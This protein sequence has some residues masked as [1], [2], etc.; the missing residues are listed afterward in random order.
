LERTLWWSSVQLRS[1]EMVLVFDDEAREPSQEEIT[2]YAEFLGIDTEKEPYLLWIAKEGVAAPIPTP[3]K[4]CQEEGSNEVFYFNFES[5]E[6]VWDH[7]CDEKYRQMAEDERLKHDKKEDG[8]DVRSSPRRGPASGV[9]VDPGEPPDEEGGAD[10]SPA[11]TP[12]SV[13]S[14]AKD[15]TLKANGGTGSQAVG[16]KVGLGAPLDEDAS[17][18]SSVASL[19]SP[20]GA[21]YSSSKSVNKAL[22]SWGNDMSVSKSPKSASKSPKAARGDAGAGGSPAGVTASQ[23]AHMTTTQFRDIRA[24]ALAEEEEEDFDKASAEGSADLDASKGSASG[25]LGSSKGSNK[26]SAKSIGGSAGNNGMTLPCINASESESSGSADSSPRGM[27]GIIKSQEAAAASASGAL[28]NSVSPNEKNAGLAGKQRSIDPSNLLAALDT[29]YSEGESMSVAQSPPGDESGGLLIDKRTGETRQR[30]SFEPAGGTQ[31]TRIE[32]SDEESIASSLP[33]SPSKESAGGS[34]AS[35]PLNAKAGSSA[36][37]VPASPSNESACNSASSTPL[38]H[39]KGGPP[40]GDQPSTPSK[41]SASGSAA[42]TP[43]GANSS[44]DFRTQKKSNKN[45]SESESDENDDAWGTNGGRQAPGPATLSALGSLLQETGS[46]KAEISFASTKAGANKPKPISTVDEEDE[47][48]VRDA[49]SAKRSPLKESAS[50]SL[51]ASQ[52]EE[53]PAVPAVAC[54]SSAPSACYSSAPSMPEE[55]VAL[56]SEVVVKKSSPPQSSLES[57]LRNLSD[58]LDNLREIRKQQQECLTCFLGTEAAE[59]SRFSPPAR[60]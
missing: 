60:R 16:M 11:S 37:E 33:G 17:V 13:T 42:S 44:S 43:A 25:G 55:C 7:P 41:L 26:G 58:L 50:A 36:R 30:N 12:A 35:T 27:A 15:K 8:S 40:P 39:A 3:W 19:S 54:Y 48:S 18:D 22:K 4:A 20:N 57:Q 47:D 23:L 32:V 59:F 46:A 49:A 31:V 1:L 38:G 14:S 21:S 34:A 45:D 24:G 9:K 2:D 56:V 51:E 29:S 52:A 53:V 10:S 28:S 5:S 6:S